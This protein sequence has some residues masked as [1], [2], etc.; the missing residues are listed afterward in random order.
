M[1]SGC[2]ATSHAAADQKVSRASV[3]QPPTRDADYL[4]NGWRG[5]RVRRGPQR[6]QRTPRLPSINSDL[7]GHAESPGT[8]Q[9][10]GKSH[11]G[12]AEP[13]GQ[14]DLE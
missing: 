10:N 13:A 2:T 9:D 12:H 1:S 14:A 11:G 4:Y 7:R 8:Y 5:L 6:P 3:R